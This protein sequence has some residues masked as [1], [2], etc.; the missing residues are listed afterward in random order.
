LGRFERALQSYLAAYEGFIRTHDPEHAAVVAQMASDTLAS[1]GDYER[2]WEYHREAVRRLDVLRDPRRRYSLLAGAGATARAQ[3]LAG[4]AL[5]L[6]RAAVPHAYAFGRP[7]AIVG[8][9]QNLARAL[10]DLGERTQALQEI[11]RAEAQVSRI[12]D[13]GL[14]AK[15]GS[16]LLVAKAT[17]LLETDP[18]AANRLI[19]KALEDYGSISSQY[20]RASLH[21]VQGRARRA[22]GDLDGARQT[23]EQGLAY[24]ESTRG[25]TTQV[26]L[27]VSY[28]D[29]VWELYGD[30]IRL[31]AVDRHE[32]DRALATAERARA[33]TLLDASRSGEAA[34]PSDPR[35]IAAVLPPGHSIL[36]LVTFERETFAWLLRS[37]RVVFHRLS[38]GSREAEKAIARIRGVLAEGQDAAALLRD[39][40]G[41]LLSPLQAALS[42]TSRLVVVAD[43]TWQPLPFASLQNPSTGRFLIE[44]VTLVSTP[45]AS[46]YAH[47][48]SRKSL[49]VPARASVFAVPGV[50]GSR[51]VLP[52]LPHAAAE[53]TEIAHAYN[54]SVLW[55]GSDAT[56]TRFIGA[57]REFDVVHFAGHAVADAANPW[58]SRLV[59]SPDSSGR[60][61]VVASDLSGVRASARVVVLAACRTADGPASRGEGLMSLA[62]PLL[63]AGVSSVAATLWDVEDRDAADILVRFHRELRRSGDAADALR[64]AQLALLQGRHNRGI[65]AWAPYV[66]VGA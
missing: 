55:I 36:Y 18:A 8:A 26:A 13:P 22:T 21:L 1:L 30:L 19:E 53:A 5:H 44:D 37:D 48:A 15:F 16:D 11:R 49:P 25:L 54:P 20:A 40:H 28:L 31:Q 47:A 38:I 46:I 17:V 62:R 52:L 7:A 29:S 60:A 24:L 39:L 35:R 66:I 57:L 61:E 14:A 12:D 56:P 2:S 34:M 65:G 32:T 27:R 64:R 63:G 4:A 6:Y 41:R 3:G 9:H 33:R 59:L 58:N 45:S 50:G 10:A 51:Q 42:G 43:G 23:L